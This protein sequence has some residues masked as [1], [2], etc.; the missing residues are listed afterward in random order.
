MPFFTGNN[1]YTKEFE[2]VFVS[3]DGKEW[4]NMPYTLEEAR[5]DKERRK[6]Q[7]VLDEISEYC[8]RKNLNS[9]KMAYSEIA[10]KKSGLSARCKKWLINFIENINK[11]EEN[12]K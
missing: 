6:E 9:F 1:Y 8:D 10:E 3:P 2:G 4:S 7:R 5:I 12:G 11:N